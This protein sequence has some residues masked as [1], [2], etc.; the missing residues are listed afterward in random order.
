LSSDDIPI[1]FELDDFNIERGVSYGGGDGPLL[2]AEFD[3]YSFRVIPGPGAWCLLLGG[4]L[5]TSRRRP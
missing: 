2:Q 4:S 5:L 3:S 1:D